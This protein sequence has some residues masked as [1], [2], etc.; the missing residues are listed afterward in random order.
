MKFV[1]QRTDPI[2]CFSVLSKGE[3]FL[4]NGEPFL[5]IDPIQ[6]PHRIFNAVNLVDGN[7]WTLGGEE[8][9]EK[10]WDCELVVKG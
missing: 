2:I 5:K 3:M 4:F 1:D 8:T 10:I 6:T 7:P 9:I